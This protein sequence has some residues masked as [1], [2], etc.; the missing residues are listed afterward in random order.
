MGAWLGL[1]FGVAVLAT[2]DATAFYI[3]DAP[4][5]I[6]TV[7]LKG[8]AAGFLAGL[9]YEWLS[10]KNIYWGTIAAAI[11]CPIVNTGVFLLGCR[12]FFWDTIQTW[13]LADN[14]GQM[15]PYLI[16][17]MGL[18]NFPFELGSNLVLSPVL[19]RLLRISKKIRG[20]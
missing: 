9:T 1:I 5:T 19:L 11:V 12:L 2:G 8:T 4:G 13:A 14:G 16:F 18:I 15:I 3:V 10:K 20:M 17:G 6:A 7:L